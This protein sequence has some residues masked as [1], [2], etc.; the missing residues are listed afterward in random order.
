MGDR[1]TAKE[2]ERLNNSDPEWFKKLIVENDPVFLQE[3]VGERFSGLMEK[4]GMA[5]A[6][7]IRRSL[8]SKS[9]VYQVLK[10]ER[11]ASREVLIKLCIAIGCPLLQKES[12]RSYPLYH[13]R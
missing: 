3:T 8:L 13:S 9:Y 7:V 12:E 1:L 6:E 5:P 11:Q 2:L 4:Y 10:G